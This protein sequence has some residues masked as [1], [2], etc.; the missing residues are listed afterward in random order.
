LNDPDCGECKTVVTGQQIGLLG[1]P[2][3][4]TYKVLGAIYLAKQINGQAVYWLE[5][6]DADFNEINHIDYLDAKGNLQ[7][8]KWDID[9]GGFSC[10]YIETDSRL[11]A[12]LE[13]FFDTIRQTEYTDELKE[14]VLDCYAPGRLLGDASVRLANFLFEGFDLQFFN[15]AT[16]EFRD[17]SKKI[18]LKEAEATPDGAQCN[19][20]CMVGHQRKTLFKID[21]QFQLR[22]GTIVNLEAHDLVPNVKSRNICQDAYFNAHTYVAGPGEVKYI[23]QL[24]DNYTFHGVKKAAVQ[25]RMS[26]SLLEPRVKRLLGKTDL[27]LADVLAVSKEELV[28]QI[29]KDQS[30]SGLD[31]NRSLQ[32]GMDV[33]EDYLARLTEIGLEVSEI[34]GLRKYLRPEIKKSLGKLRAREKEK[35]QRVLNDVGYLSDNLKPWGKKQERIFNI[36][37]Y[38]NLYGG[39]DFIKKIYDHYDWQR[40]Q[41][42]IEYGK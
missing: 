26:I 42:E 21:G 41:L 39:V 36:L 8:L 32:A 27:S 18:L 38:M 12:I 28:K 7:S 31:F 6:N 22:D 15:P 25:P 16:P 4:T 13:T 35:H 24:D 20:F 19:L 23:A 1:G 2:L 14:R 5:T 11:T 9:S 40:Q 17:F 30:D 33:T 34:K 37:Y 29:L 10:G 3:Y